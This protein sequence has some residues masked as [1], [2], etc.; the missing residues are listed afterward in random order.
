[1]ANASRKQPVL[2]SLQLLLQANDHTADPQKKGVALVGGVKSA[3]AVLPTTPTLHGVAME[4]L[5]SA[6]QVL[7]SQHERNTMD[8]SLSSVLSGA[9]TVLDSLLEHCPEGWSI[10]ILKWAVGLLGRLSM[11]RGSPSAIDEAMKLWLTHPMLAPIIG[12]V[13]KCTEHLVSL[14]KADQCV[15][16]VLRACCLHTPR[17]CWLMAHIITLHPSH[18]LH[19]LLTLC[20]SG[21]ASDKDPAFSTLCQVM[22]F[23]AETHRE[24]MRLCGVKVL[25]GVLEGREG[26]SCG[27]ALAVLLSLAAKSQPVL[28]TVSSHILQILTPAKISA[29]VARSNGAPPPEE[30]RDEMEEEE[31]EGEIHSDEEG[32]EEGGVAE[33]KRSEESSIS[34]QELAQRLARVVCLLR[35]EE[36]GTAISYLIQVYREMRQQQRSQGQ[37]TE[38][39]VTRSAHRA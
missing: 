20:L 18:L 7:F 24:A 15:G 6:Y 4:T 22:E 30:S 8:S 2:A 13:D 17:L 3:V 36:A 37:H 10:K 25:E 32:A 11:T 5:T 12:F 31:D 23:L 34:P 28:A 39:G 38:P 21:Q 14:G 19:S 29:L 35:G 33:E 9:C 1:M 16:C 27:S 26:P